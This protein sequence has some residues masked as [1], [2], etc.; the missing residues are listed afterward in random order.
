MYFN[1]L[2]SFLL[3]N[4]Y[5]RQQKLYVAYI[6]GWLTS[7]NPS[8]KRTECFNFESVRS[9]MKSFFGCGSSVGIHSRP[10]ENY[11][12]LSTGKQRCLSELFLV[13]CHVEYVE[14]KVISD[15]GV[16]VTLPFLSALRGSLRATTRLHLQP[17][18][19]DHVVI[20]ALTCTPSVQEMNDFSR[21]VVPQR[22]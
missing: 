17:L 3:L 12:F 22:A 11:N 6:K 14:T 18:E 13:P 21:T 9:F 5:Q 16:S 10:Q 20:S 1:V 2:N 8:K 4:K 19:C 15:W 7:H